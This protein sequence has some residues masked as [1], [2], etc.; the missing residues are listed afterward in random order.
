MS[1]ETPVEA[2]PAAPAATVEPARPL[3][4]VATPERIA[5]MDVLRGFALLGILLMNVEFFFRPMQ[6]IYLGLD[7]SLTGVDAV[8][9]W[10][11][12][13]FVQGKFYTL[14]SM[15]FGMGFAIQ[16]ERAA[17]RG[18]GFGGVYVRRLLALL[19]FG[20]AH[21]VLIWAGDILVPYALM[22]FA[23]LLFRKTP[24]SRLPKWAAGLLLAPMALMSIFVLVT[25]LAAS[26]PVASEQ[27]AKS[28]AD[29]EQR[30]LE[31]AAR[32]ETVYAEGT[33]GEITRQ[34]VDDVAQQLAFLPVFGITLLG[35][36]LL[37][38]WFVRSGTMPRAAE[39]LP[40][41]RRMLAIGLGAGVPLAVAA[42]FLGYGEG[43]LRISPR[44]FA[45][46]TLMTVAALLL[47][48]GYLAAVV[49]LVQRPAWRARL[50]P[51]AAA[52][53]MALTNYILQSVVMTAIAY[54]WGLGLFGKVARAWQIPLAI[55]VWALNVALSS[56]WLARFRFGPLEWLWRSLTYLRAQPMRA[57][58]PPPVD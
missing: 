38:A 42:M 51:L 4:P 45:A 55:A 50:A 32:A 35:L 10:L 49:L 30:V 7:R 1:E 27:I 13:A 19:A 24:V 41:Y 20:L 16:L 28:Q 47:S 39:H 22:G 26:N 43:L 31:K 15:L 2:P 33:P 52:G 37:G 36:F 23:L 8:A 14:F 11:V 5:E 12:M 58:A 25:S 34:R 54:S 57:P 6:G 46:A 3:A 18:A 56:W 53:R 44:A 40:R 29:S 17:A 9:A 48:F 21:G